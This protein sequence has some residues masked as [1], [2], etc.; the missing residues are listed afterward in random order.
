MTT[1]IYLRLSSAD[2]N[3]NF[4]N[5][6][7]IDSNSIKNQRDLLTAFVKNHADLRDS[8]IIEIC[9]DG[10]S[11]T[12][13][14]RPGVKKLLE[15]VKDGGVN[16][17]V[18]KDFSRFARN[19]IEAGDYIEQIFPFLGVRF[20]SVNDGYD[21]V[22]QDVSAGN[23]N[24]AFM[25][26]IHDLYSKD[27]SVKVRT[28]QRQKWEKGEI[29]AAYT[30][31]GYVKSPENKHQVIIDEPAAKTVRQIFDMAVNGCKTTKIAKILNDNGVCTPNG[32]K[33]AEGYK[34]NYITAN[35]PMF[36]TDK[37]VRTI[38][39]D[40]RYM[41]IAIFG[42]TKS[43][44]LGSRITT[45]V[46]RSDWIVRENAFDAVVSK[47]IYWKAQKVLKRHSPTS[48][49]SENR[50]LV[51][52]TV[53]GGCGRALKR[54][55]YKEPVFICRTPGFT[56]SPD[57]FCGRIAEKELEHIL[58]GTIRQQIEIFA[59]RENQKREN[60]DLLDT[61]RNELTAQIQNLQNSLR[62]FESERILLYE[63]YKDG[64]ISRDDY[65]PEREKINTEIAMLENMLQS[66]EFE[67]TAQNEPKL[68][69]KKYA[70]FVGFAELT[71]EMVDCLV[72]SIIVYNGG[73][74]EVIL[75]CYD[76]F[77]IINNL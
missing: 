73:R 41:G 35:M 39:K 32:Y 12:S 2:E 33:I 19:Y 5:A 4:A 72:G 51:Y 21:S 37:V 38:I 58:F 20:I 76:E 61:E 24:V 65:L 7:I 6:E 75:K 8:Q 52:K 66:L 60:G 43:K 23:L 28:A 69:V 70:K 29:I 27:L 1:A 46:G 62:Q 11:G 44:A 25:N 13:F 50:R 68:A 57:C 49:K 42:K 31:F 63:R 77:N 48:K 18:V 74:A 16:C 47:D 45:D 9:D 34:R 30:I 14:N 10:F 59:E 56:N 36:W 22:E 64:E 67:Q 53:C 15:L 55:A 26:L 3:K 40:E 71:R 54:L 17:V